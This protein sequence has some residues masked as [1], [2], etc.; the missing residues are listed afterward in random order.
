MNT[1]CKSTSIKR[2]ARLLNDEG[3]LSTEYVHYLGKLA[4]TG[5]PRAARVIARYLDMGGV[6]GH[7]AARSLLW[8]AQSSSECREV[9][10]RI[11]QRRIARSL[12]FDEIRNAQEVC[13][14]LA[15]DL[16]LRNAA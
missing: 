15:R 5:N 14:E 1:N 6:V 8:L 16:P 2:L 13:D 11:C 9:V 12:D 4:E 10:L 7:C 3:N